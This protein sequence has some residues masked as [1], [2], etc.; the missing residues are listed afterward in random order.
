M[1]N[2]RNFI[3]STSL[4]STGI[5]IFPFLESFNGKDSTLLQLEVY[6]TNWGFKGTMEEFCKK[7]MQ[8][9]Y[10][11]IEVWTPK[12][13]SKRNNLLKLLEKYNLKLGLLA[14][15]WGDNY[16]AHS[17]EFNISLKNAT[18]MHPEFI[19]CHSGKDYFNFEQ[20]QAFVDIGQTWYAK[21]NTPIYHETHR[22]RMLYAAHIADNYLKANADLRLTLDI[23]HW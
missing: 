1:L 13:E 6:A 20:N 18:G 12:E 10:D 17:N 2:R 22:G 4:I 9:G 23:S 16:E 11:G 7:A 15:N 8:D 21:T 14:G 5:P 19:N 3:K